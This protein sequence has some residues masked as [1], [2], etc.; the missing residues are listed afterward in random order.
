MFGAIERRV[1][2][3]HKIIRRNF[4]IG[5]Q[6]TR[7]KAGGEVKLPSLNIEWLGRN[8]AAEAFGVRLEELLI[9]ARC[10]DHELLAAVPTE[11]VVGALRSIDAADDRPQCLV[12][13]LVSEAVVNVLE[14]IQI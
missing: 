11:R 6:R 1:G 3:T 12:A 5:L 4:E 2:G 13:R 14:V 8:R 10:D 7:S 9:A